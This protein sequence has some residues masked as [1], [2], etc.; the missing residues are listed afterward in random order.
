MLGITRNEHGAD[1]KLDVRIPS[2]AIVDFTVCVM[3]NDICIL[4]FLIILIYIHA[5][6]Y[7]ERHLTGVQAYTSCMAH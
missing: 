4:S 7:E 6:F 5:R 3:S 1:L 2:S